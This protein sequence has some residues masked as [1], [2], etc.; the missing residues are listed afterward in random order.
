MSALLLAER[1][2]RLRAAAR[3]T[4]DGSVPFTPAWALELPTTS[5]VYI[6]SDLR[7]PLY[8]GMTRDLRR[9]FEKHYA[10]THNP[11]LAEA[12]QHPAGNPCFSWILTPSDHLESLER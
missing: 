7:G 2:V 4:I 1:R 3:L 10:N 5:G 9:R 6:I 11:W 12:L 8:V